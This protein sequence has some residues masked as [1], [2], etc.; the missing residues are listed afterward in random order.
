MGVI[1]RV[2]TMNRAH[3]LAL[4]RQSRPADRDA[5][6]GLEPRRRQGGAQSTVDD[7]LI[8]N[9]TTDIRA[10]GFDGAKS[11][12]SPTAIRSSSSRWRGSA[13][14]ISAICTR[15]SRSRI[16]AIGQ[17][18]VVMVP[19]DG[20]MTMSAG[21]DDGDSEGAEGTARPADALFRTSDAKSVPVGRRRGFD[22]ELGR[23]PEMVV[24]VRTLPERPKVLVLLG[25]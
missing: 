1:P 23:V 13:S 6:C 21:R 12:E 14:A 5:C 22:A 19:V 7:V 18:D 17:L 3:H 2:V 11:G 4:H 16:A 10:Y 9:V 15:C 20:S 24:S 25:Y 8:R